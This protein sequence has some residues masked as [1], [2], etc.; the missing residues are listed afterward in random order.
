[1]AS[2]AAILFTPNVIVTASITYVITTMIFNAGID[3]YMKHVIDGE[4]L[5]G[6][7]S[8]NGAVAEATADMRTQV[9]ELEHRLDVMNHKNLRVQELEEDLDDTRERLAE[10]EHDVD[11]AK[12]TIRQREE[13]LGLLGFAI[14]CM[15]IVASM[16]SLLFI[17]EMRH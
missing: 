2:L 10:L 14:L 3:G 9:S 12:N 11:V 16:S 5:R 8:K 6:V 1:M 7:L 15:T 4:R 13:M 17:K